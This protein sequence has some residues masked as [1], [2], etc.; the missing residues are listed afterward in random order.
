MTESFEDEFEGLVLFQGVEAAIE[1]FTVG[2]ALL[3]GALREEMGRARTIEGVRSCAGQLRRL[4]SLVAKQMCY[5]GELKAEAMLA[6]DSAL[7]DLP[8]IEV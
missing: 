7:A 4:R 2:Y 5:V 6:D 1:Q 3:L 8:A